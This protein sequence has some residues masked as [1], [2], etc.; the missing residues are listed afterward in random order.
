MIERRSSCSAARWKQDISIT[1][2][3]FKIHGHRF[4]MSPD[5]RRSRLIDPNNGHLEALM[6]TK[7]WSEIACL[8]L[9]Y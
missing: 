7:L 5:S 4:R 3:K 9:R 2:D 1:L 8:I 6:L